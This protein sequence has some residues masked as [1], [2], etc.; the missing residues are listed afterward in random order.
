MCFKSSGMGFF[1]LLHKYAKGG[2][3]ILGAMWVVE[4]LANFLYDSYIITV[5]FMISCACS[6]VKK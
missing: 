5:T 2:K 1:Y 6:A 4:L 3:K